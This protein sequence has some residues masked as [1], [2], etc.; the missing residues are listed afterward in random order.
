MRLHTLLLTCARVGRLAPPCA[1]MGSAASSRIEVERKFA[2]PEGG[3]AAGALAAGA[4][5]VGEARFSDEY[6]DTA[7]CD[8]TRTDTWLR[9]RRLQ[10]EPKGQW[11]LKLPVRLLRVEWTYGGGV[12]LGAGGGMR[13]S[14]TVC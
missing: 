13:C 5:L 6:W 3:I 8:L 12:S 7:Q 4:E 2:A 14:N 9:L 10:A 11:E 1:S